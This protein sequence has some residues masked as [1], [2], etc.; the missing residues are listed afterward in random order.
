MRACSYRNRSPR[1]WCC[2]ASP[3]PSPS[4]PSAPASA[5]SPTTDPPSPRKERGGAETP[6]LRHSPAIGRLHRADHV[7]DL[8]ERGHVGGAALVRR[9]AAGGHVVV[10]LRAGRGDGGAIAAHLG[11]L[12]IVQPFPVGADLALAAQRAGGGIG[13]ERIADRAFP[14][15]RQGVLHA[16]AGGASLRLG[17]GGGLRHGGGGAEAERERGG[18]EKLAGHR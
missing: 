11:L 10:G 2:G 18:N 4:A 7:A 5:C 12:V 14:A 13:E 15:A 6:P 17:G 1:P 16:R 9:H 3:P 8:L